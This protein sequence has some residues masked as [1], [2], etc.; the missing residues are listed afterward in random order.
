MPN[1]ARQDGGANLFRVAKEI[2]LPGALTASGGK[3][4]SI[5]GQNSES[6][7]FS[8]TTIKHIRRAQKLNYRWQWRDFF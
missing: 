5:Y 1:A 7:R 3:R 2:P 4:Q 8:A 6:W